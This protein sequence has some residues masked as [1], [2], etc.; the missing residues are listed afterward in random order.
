MKKTILTV[1]IGL[2][3]CFFI[4]EVVAQSPAPNTKLRN[5]KGG[6]KKLNSF[7]GK[8]V[9]VDFWASWCAPCF[10]AMPSLT[11]L[12]QE[13]GDDLVIVTVNVD[14]SKKAWKKGY[15][16]GRPEGIALWAGSGGQDS[17]IAK[18]LF[19]FA[20]PQYVLIDQNGNVVDNVAAG[21]YQVKDEIRNLIQGNSASK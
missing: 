17:R 14:K 10:T 7:K 5:I 21:P 8:V 15:K 3:A 20:L 11:S 6:K 1:L 16:K 13:F 19:V 12:K 2:M 18:E 9:Y 4:G